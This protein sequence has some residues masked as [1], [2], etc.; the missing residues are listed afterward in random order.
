MRG[1]GPISR[2]VWFCATG[3]RKETGPNRQPCRLCCGF[4]PDIRKH[5]QGSQPAATKN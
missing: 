5:F 2:A 3:C 1:R 4:T